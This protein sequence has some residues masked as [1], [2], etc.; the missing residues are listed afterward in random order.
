MIFC[1][2]NEKK[3]ISTTTNQKKNMKTP[4][5]TDFI[6]QLHVFHEILILTA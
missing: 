1:V 6:I 5:F 3:K 2:L 4:F